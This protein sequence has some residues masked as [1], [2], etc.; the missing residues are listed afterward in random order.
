V[1]ESP[2]PALRCCPG[3]GRTL[4]PSALKWEIIR[5]LKLAPITGTDRQQERRRLEVLVLLFPHDHLPRGGVDPYAED[6]PAG[7]P[8]GRTDSRPRKPRGAGPPP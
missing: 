8:L 1:R 4:P 5:R 6:R 2:P 3:C 7:R